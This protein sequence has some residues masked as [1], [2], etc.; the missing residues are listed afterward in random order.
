M[1]LVGVANPMAHGQAMTR[2]AT[3]LTSASG[4]A[5]TGPRK[6]QARKVT[7]ATAM[8]M[9]TK[10]ATT[11]SAKAWMGGLLPCA[12]STI[13]MMRAK[14]VSAP[15]ARASNRNEP[16]LLMVPPTTP[17]PSPLC[18]GTLSPVIIDSST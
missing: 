12:A 17:A 5:G 6:Y 16:V 2:T 3:A 15:T 18:T 9:G 14:T 10:T 8:T 4:N 7:T 13:S 11:R 1:T